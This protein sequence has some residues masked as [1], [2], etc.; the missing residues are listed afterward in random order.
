MS[1]HN[2]FNNFNPA[3][4]NRL[5][6]AAS[7]PRTQ[8]DSSRDEQPPPPTELGPM[9]Q[10]HCVWSRF[11]SQ[12]K[13]WMQ[14]SEGEALSRQ[15]WDQWLPDLL[16]LCLCCSPV[17]KCDSWHVFPQVVSRP[18]PRYSGFTPI[19]SHPHT[20]FS[21]RPNEKHFL[22]DLSSSSP[23]SVACVVQPLKGSC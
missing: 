17:E 5:V 1:S 22:Q 3:P 15:H 7:Q 10:I 20:P 4:G 14:T 8:G 16:E 21:C 11:S 2:H 19:T 9:W 23:G 12:R 13:R 6:N 18:A